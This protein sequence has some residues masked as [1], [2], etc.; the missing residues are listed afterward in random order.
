MLVLSSQSGLFWEQL[1][2][3]T[4]PRATT[5]SLQRHTTIPLPTSSASSP[6]AYGT[7]SRDRPPC[8]RTGQTLS[9]TSTKR[10]T[11]PTR[12]TGAP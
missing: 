11:G 10:G 9:A 3:D 8:H 7:S 5:A 4:K 6:T 1:S 2:G 12:T